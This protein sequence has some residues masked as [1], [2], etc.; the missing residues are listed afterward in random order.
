L[1][2]GEPRAPLR[3]RYPRVEEEKVITFNQ[4]IRYAILA[5]SVGLMILGAFVM[6]GFRVPTYFPAEYRV[7][8][9]LVV[10]LYG[11]YRFSIAYF[12]RAKE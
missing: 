4:T 6:A 12:R 10:F 1:P 3:H 11:A 7:I 9:G 2:A 5:L 8:L